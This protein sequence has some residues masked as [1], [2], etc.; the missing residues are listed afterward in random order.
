MLGYNGKFLEVDLSNSSFKDI[1]VPDEWLI[2]YIGGRALAAKI[3]SERLI[4]KWEKVDPLG[5]ENLYYLNGFYCSLL[6]FL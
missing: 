6:L 4:A 1:R 5:P 3:L 2:D